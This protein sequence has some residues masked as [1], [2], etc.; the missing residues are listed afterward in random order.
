MPEIYRSQHAGSIADLM[1]QRGSAAA[2][3]ARQ[4]GDLQAQRAMTSGQAIQNITQ[5]VTGTLRDF[6]QQRQEAPMMALRQRQADQI[7]AELSAMET[8]TAQKRIGELAAMV[9][10]NNYDPATAEPVFRA[11]AK[12]SPEYEQPLLRSLMEPAMLKNVTDTLISQ[13]PGYKAPEGFTLSEGQTRFGPD[14]KQIANVPKPEPVQQPYTL[15]PGSQRR[16]PNNEVLA[17]VPTAPRTVNMQ[18]AEVLLDG[19]PSM[20]VFNPETGTY[21]VNGQDVTS[22]VRPIPPQGPAPER[23]SVWVQ[24][25][26]EQRFVTPTEAAQLTGAGWGPSQ[27]RENPT[28]DERKTAGFHARMENAI[29]IMDEVEDQIGERDLYQI[30][31]LPQED[32]MGLLNR[33]QMSEAAKRY[34]RAMMQ[35]TEARLRADSGAAISM[36]EYQA[37]RQMYAKQYGETP[38]LNTDRRGARATA[39]EG[40]R[41]RAGRA[42]PRSGTQTTPP[43]KPEGSVLSNDPNAGEP[44]RTPRRP[45]GG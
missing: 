35:F 2:S 36:A 18:R 44:I 40:L 5:G 9:R 10:A 29:K 28:E 3:H 33:G 13:T 17:E 42:M 39:L 21:T 25:G 41:T 7:A 43:P 23:P 31:S 34:V 4:L 12:L 27:T 45:G 19:K 14:G 26:T 1:R 30:Q 20:A 6:A 8:A 24:K 38:Q 37:D 22:R 16:G 15:T 32:L 11:I